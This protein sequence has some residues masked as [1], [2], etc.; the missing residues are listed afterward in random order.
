MFADELPDAPILLA[1]VKPQGLQ[2]MGVKI[3]SMLTGGVRYQPVIQVGPKAIIGVSGLLIAGDPGD[4]FS[5]G[6]ASGRDGEATGEWLEL[7][8]TSPDGT[9][10]T[11]RRTLL[12][13]VGDTARQAGAFDPGTLPV[14]ELVDLDPDHP[15]EYLPLTTI[16]HLSIATG[17]MAWPEPDTAAGQ[18]AAALGFPARM[19]HV[20]RD[21]ANAT[22]SADRGV[23]IHVPAPN[24][25]MHS[26]ELHPDPAGA[27]TV[28]ETLDLL[29][30]SFVGRPV[31]GSVPAAPAGVLAGV[32]SHVAERLRGGAG[33][34]ADLAPATPGPSVGAIFEQATTDGIALRVLRGSC[35]R[36]WAIRPR[37]R[38]TW[39]T[40]SRVAG[41]PSHPSDPC[42]SG[43]SRDWA[44]GSWTPPPPPRSTCSTTGAGSRWS[45]PSH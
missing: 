39:R 2:G 3:G 32:T 38:R 45:R 5:T 30:R 24:V 22:L 12:D 34:P 4:P 27:M 6:G 43:T 21:V 19:Y 11:A 29:H 14:A 10:A 13:R 15:A 37:P 25:L 28:T 31:T 8:I 17:G 42:G 36:T 9:T 26:Y 44:G 20:T 18:E 33:L 40:R 41:W 35:R 7:R 23:A 16:R 1:H